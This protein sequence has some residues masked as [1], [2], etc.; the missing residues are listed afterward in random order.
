MAEWS[1]E[2]A[3]ELVRSRVTVTRKQRGGFLALCPCPGHNDRHQSLSVRLSDDGKAV[4]VS[5]F[6]G[7]NRDDIYAAMGM[8]AEDVRVLGGANRRGRPRKAPAPAPATSKKKKEWEVVKGSEKWIEDYPYF[9][10]ETGAFEFATVRYQITLRHVET[11]ETRLS[12]EIRQKRPAPRVDPAVLAKS[13]DMGDAVRPGRVGDAFGQ[14]IWSLSAGWFMLRQ[15]QGGGIY[16]K[17]VSR[18]GPE[19]KPTHDEE[20]KGRPELPAGAVLEYLPEVRRDLWR[21]DRVRAAVRDRRRIWLVE[22]EKDVKALEKRGETATTMPMGA[23]KEWLPQYTQALSG[24]GEIINVADKDTPGYRHALRLRRVLIEHCDVFRTVQAVEG[25]DAA[26]HLAVLGPEDF[27][28]IAERL[29]DLAEEPDAEAAPSAPDEPAEG[30]PHLSVVE[31]GGSSETPAKEPAKGGGRGRGPR[32]PDGGVVPPE[33]PPWRRFTLTDL[34]NAERLVD[35]LK[36]DAR[37]CSKLNCWFFWSETHWEEDLT[38]GSFILRRAQAL[39]RDMDAIGK[40]MKKARADWLE[41]EGLPADTSD[42]PTGVPVSK[43]PFRVPSAGEIEGWTKHVRGSRGGS[44]LNYMQSIA[45]GLGDVPV[46]PKELDKG[47][48]LLP[49]RNG[50]IDLRTGEMV[51]PNREDMMTMF[52]DV[53]Y[54]PK[55]DCPLFMDFLVRATGADRPGDE[56]RQGREAMQFLQRAMGYSLSGEVSEQK[57]FF[58]YGEGGTGK[59][60]I[61]DVMAGILGEF[62]RALDKNKLMKSRFEGEIPEW[63]ARLRNARFVPAV[64]VMGEDRFDEGLIKKMTGGDVL[65]ARQMRKDSFDFRPQFKLWLSGNSRPTIYGTDRGIW[66]RFVMVPFENQIP[67]DA[68]IPN[69]Y[70]KLLE[71][72]E[73]IF[74]FMVDGAKKWYS[75]DDGGL[76]IPQR[77]LELV[78]DYRAEQDVVGQFLGIHTVPDPGDGPDDG[79]MAEP[80]LKSFN[81]W[82]KALS[83]PTFSNVKFAR[84]MEGRKG[85]RKEKTAKGMKYFGIRLVEDDE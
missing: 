79:V 65:T 85:I 20:Q 74:A 7:C 4:W 10:G 62:H 73:G 30:G 84:M 1:A 55:A 3:L 70:K 38:D 18:G 51:E 52:V 24:A 43:L 41:D 46:T 5:C 68:M 25:K 66:R 40:A 33:I 21:L 27:E 9:N 78:D 76:K 19:D 67:S 72:K 11:G 71:E 32:T 28:D 42:G 49:V 75:K 6:A 53:T 14:W 12:K 29:H 77:F 44:K 54:N 81:A 58:L 36:S 56:G 22:G 57:L 60:T 34:G 45:R 39:L 2:A 13:F 17:R 82:S 83:G 80:L 47:L 23:G 37:Y 26:D 50:V 15:A 63:L 48:H 35:A 16:W 69:F 61:I 64:E 31:G 59:S 8:S